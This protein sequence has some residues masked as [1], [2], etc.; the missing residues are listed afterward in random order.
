MLEFWTEVVTVSDRNEKLKTCNYC[1]RASCY[2]ET[3]K[4][5]HCDLVVGGL[6]M[7]PKIQ[8]E[9]CPFFTYSENFPKGVWKCRIETP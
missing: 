3:D 9:K 5:V 6:V 7:F 2:K 4:E 8:A 1:R